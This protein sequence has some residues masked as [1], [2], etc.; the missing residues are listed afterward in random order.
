MLC[1]VLC[2]ISPRRDLTLIIFSGVA[3]FAF[4][5]FVLNK[6]RR[7]V[8]AGTSCPSNHSA[9]TQRM[10]RGPG[11]RASPGLKGPVRGP[12]RRASPGLGIRSN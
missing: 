2:G 7:L 10:V 3:W 4:Q 8:D 1:P 9:P 5:N 11:R 6:S 12:G